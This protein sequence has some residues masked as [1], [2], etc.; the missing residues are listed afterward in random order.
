[1]KF[2][3]IIQDSCEKHYNWTELYKCVAL[4]GSEAVYIPL[5]RVQ[6][7]HLQ[8]GYV[9]VVI[10]GDD[11]LALASENIMLR[12]GIYYNDAFF[13]VNNYI[14]LWKHNYLNCDAKIVTSSH[15]PNMIFRFLFARYG[16]ISHWTDRL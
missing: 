10:G 8:K 13:N 7:F 5:E 15:Y 6:Y 16:M 12:S 4:C 2:I 14:K 3:W 11:Y 1:M 9:P